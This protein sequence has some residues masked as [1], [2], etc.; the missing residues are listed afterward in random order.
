MFSSFL[1]KPKIVRLC[2]IAIRNQVF[3]MPRYVLD[4]V[5]YAIHNESSDKERSNG[6]V[7][8]VDLS[9]VVGVI[10]S[11]HLFDP[12]HTGFFWAHKKR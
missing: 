4:L 7:C 6:S 2:F 1:L 10:S 5:V 3:V 9:M 8:F 12:L 11:E